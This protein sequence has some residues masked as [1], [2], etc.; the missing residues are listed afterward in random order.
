MSAPEQPGAAIPATTRDEI[1]VQHREARRLRNAAEPG[2][3]EW[4]HASAEVGRL[5]VEI[6]R[7]ERAMDPPLV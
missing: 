2:G 3:P 7:I 1:L 5:E 6:A 4:E